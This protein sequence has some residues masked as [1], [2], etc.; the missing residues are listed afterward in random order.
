MI[1]SKGCEYAIRAVLYLAKQPVGKRIL[2][3]QIAENEGV[4]MHFLAKLFQTL[5][6]DG[7]VSSQKGRGGGFALAMPAEEIS[8]F[9][10]YESIDGLSF[11]GRCIFGLEGCSGESPC[12]V[13]NHWKVVKEQIGEFLK[14][15]TIADLR[16]N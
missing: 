11:F 15:N 2:I 14:G 1:Y 16:T 12:P 5:A 9:K 10:I 3:K 8:L 13:H 6:K 4:P 7:I